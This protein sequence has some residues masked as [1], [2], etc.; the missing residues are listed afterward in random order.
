VDSRSLTGSIRIFFEKVASDWTGRE[1]SYP[2]LAI[3]ESDG[4]DGVTYNADP[5]AVR[6][7]VAAADKILV[8]VHGIIG[9]TKGMAAS[10]RKKLMVDPPVALLGDRYPLILAFDYENLNTP[11]E[12]NAQKLKERLEAVG[13]SAGHG[14]QLHIAAHSMGGLVARWFIERLGGNQM[15]RHLVMLGTPNGGSPWSVAEDLVTTL[16]GF[17]LNNMTPVAWPTKALSWL[18]GDSLK[19]DVSLDQMNPKSDFLKQLAESPDPGVRYTIIAGNTSLIAPPD[20]EQRGRLR[21]L[22]DRLKPQHVFH[23]V[24]G[25]AFFGSPNDIAVSVKSIKAVP[26]GRTPAPLMTEVACDHI[27]YFSTEAGL[28][29]LADAL[30]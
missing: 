6:T 10:A 26:E 29:A 28:R 14:K 4:E 17:G 23:D 7:R 13:L 8:Y 19:I 21:R 25:L 30:V 12:Q 20:D 24:T 2:L 11:I 1:F 22:L 16:I 27:T 18:M 5:N 3:A 15:V 9:D